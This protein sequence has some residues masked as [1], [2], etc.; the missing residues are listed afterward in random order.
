MRSHQYHFVPEQIALYQTEHLLT[1][2]VCRFD[3]EQAIDR[4]RESRDVMAIDIGGDKIRSAIYSIREGRFTQETEE[5]FQSRRGV[6]YLPV[7][8]RLAAHADANDLPVGISSAT[9]LDGSVII[10]TVN[11]PVFFEE[12]AQRYDADY[13]ALFPG[14]CFVANDTITGICGAATL[15][16]LRGRPA[17]DVAFFICASGLGA[18]VIQEGRAIHVEAGHVPVVDALNPLGQ[19]TPCGVEGRDYVCVERVTAAR[20]GIENL[21][22]RRTGVAHDGMALGRMY[23]EGD[24]LATLLYEASA[25]ALAHATLGVAERYGF[26]GSEHSAVVFHGGN[27]EITRYRNEISRSLAALPGFRSRILFSRDLSTNACLDGAAILAA[28]DSHASRHPVLRQ[29]H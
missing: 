29:G 5:V 3:P 27:F 15:L 25:R 17:R 20:A 16:A 7:L 8:E 18:S 26:A 24:A 22:A 10:R 11:L 2:D 6:G 4:L 9:K 19:T 28:Y 21:Y 23:E 13:R 12:L 14:R 1:Q